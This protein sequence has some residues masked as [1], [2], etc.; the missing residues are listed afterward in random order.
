MGLFLMG[1][2]ML[3]KSLIQFYV[4]G[5]GCVPSLLFDLNS[6]YVEVM[7]IMVTSFKRSQV[8]TATLSAPNP[9]ASHH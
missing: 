6:N 2:A 1:R 9:A 8:C 7:K 3:S 4:D 5:Q